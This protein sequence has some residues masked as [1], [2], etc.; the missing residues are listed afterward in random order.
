MF[1]VLPRHTRGWFNG[2]VPR[3]PCTFSHH[4]FGLVIYNCVGVFQNVRVGPG[5]DNCEFEA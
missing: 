1:W 2:H 3:K 4:A 5:Q